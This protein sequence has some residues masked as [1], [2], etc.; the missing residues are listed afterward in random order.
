[1]WRKFLKLNRIIEKPTRT[2]DLELPIS[3]KI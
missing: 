3:H 2:H 1:M